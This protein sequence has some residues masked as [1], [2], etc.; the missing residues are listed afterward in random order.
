MSDNEKPLGIGLEEE[1]AIQSLS[2]ISTSIPILLGYVFRH[3]YCINWLKKKYQSGVI[4]QLIEADF[5]CGSW[6]P[7][8]RPETD[9]RSGVSAQKNLGGGV[10]LELSHEFDLAHFLLDEVVSVHSASV[11]QSKALDVPVEDRAAICCSTINGALV[12]FRLNFC[13]KPSR[14]ILLIRGTKG[15]LSCDILNG[16]AV[17][18]SSD[19]CSESYNYR[20]DAD[21]RFENQLRHFINC[22]VAAEPPV[23]TINDGINVLNMIQQ[24]RSCAKS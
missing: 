14:R 1:Q 2:A 9:Y 11:G 20:R 15:E 10:L 6:L 24:I 5:Y 19:G 3:D 17:H 18:T 12:T 13:T 7:D 23:C 4:G 8:W 22:I 16:I 21:E